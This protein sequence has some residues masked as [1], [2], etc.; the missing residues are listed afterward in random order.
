MSEK[1]VAGLA[2]QLMPTSE[3]A[4]KPHSGPFFK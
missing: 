2:L 4:L 1:V 3:A